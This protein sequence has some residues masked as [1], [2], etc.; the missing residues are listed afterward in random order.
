[1]MWNP[2]WPSTRRIGPA[3]VTCGARAAVSAATE[4]RSA[5]AGAGGLATVRLGAG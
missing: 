2:L 3:G 1:M 5:E 4:A